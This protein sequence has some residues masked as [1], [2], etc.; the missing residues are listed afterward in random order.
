MEYQEFWAYYIDDTHKET[1]TTCYSVNTEL[2]VIFID[3]A[4]AY[5]NNWENVPNNVTLKHTKEI[6]TTKN[7]D[8]E[9]EPKSKENKKNS[10]QKSFEVSRAEVRLGYAHPH[11]AAVL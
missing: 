5:D 4:Q 7:N 10:V 3:F 2:N 11:S 9:P 8:S 6:S 1:Q